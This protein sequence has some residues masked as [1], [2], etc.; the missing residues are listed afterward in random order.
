MRRTSTPSSCKPAYV[1]T[2]FIAPRSS[3]SRPSLLG[4]MG[5]GRATIRWP[6]SSRSVTSEAWSVMPSSSPSPSERS[7]WCASRAE[8]PWCVATLS[9]ASNIAAAG[10]STPDSPARPTISSRSSTR[11]SVTM[12]STASSSTTSVTPRMPPPSPTTNPTVATVAA[13]GSMIGAAGTST[14]S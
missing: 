10:T 2:S 9:S 11:W 7:G 5:S 12:T 14:A 13:N 8:R 4:R 6:S 1:A 3:R